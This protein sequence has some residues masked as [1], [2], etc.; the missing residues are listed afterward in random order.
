MTKK[1]NGKKI[2]K[3]GGSNVF[4]GSNRRGLYVP[5]SE[6]EQEVVHRLVEAE[7][8]QLIIHGWGILD[9]PK[10]I[11][12]DHRIG[13]KFKM[14]FNRPDAPTPVYFFDLELRT[15]TG[16]TLCKERLPAVYNGK[17]AQV[18]KGTFLDMQW[19]IAMHS[20]DPKLVKLLKPGTIGLTS[21]RQDKDTGEMTAQ[22]NMRLDSNQKK[23][24]AELE[25]AQ[26][27][28]RAE[29]VAQVVKLTQ[30]AGYEVKRTAKG[31]VA[32]DL[33]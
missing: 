10:F 28:N 5:M 22:G 1:K 32:P 7:D 15:R 30:A 2:G 31:L 4:G 26:A 3:H 16:I 20:M 6:D 11:I 17:P 14:T 12:G 21:R 19:D 8:I 24:L 29:D 25:A 18:M 13:V 9:R 33:D 23:A 27:A